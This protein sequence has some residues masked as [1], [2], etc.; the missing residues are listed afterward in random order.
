RRAAK[1]Q[2]GTD[3]SSCAEPETLKQGSTEMDRIQLPTNARPE[4]YDVFIRPDPKFF[5]HPELLLR[6]EGSVLI[7]VRIDEPTSELVLNA[8]E[9]NF[10]RALLDGEDSAAIVANEIEQTVTLVFE[11]E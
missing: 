8:I 3:W 2:V 10:Y 1:D 5:V 7:R 4:H 9:L 11:R 6:F